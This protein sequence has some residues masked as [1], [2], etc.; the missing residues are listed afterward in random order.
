MRKPYAI[1][2]IHS[3]GH[4]DT[5][6]AKNGYWRHHGTIKAAIGAA[7]RFATVTEATEA[8]NTITR[9]RKDDYEARCREE[10]IEPDDGWFA[11]ICRMRVIDLSRMA[12]STPCDRR[13]FLP[14]ELIVGEKPVNVSGLMAFT[15]GGQP[16]KCKFCHARVW[17]HEK[18][19][20]YYDIGGEQLHHCP[21]KD[22]YH[23]QRNAELADA[24]RQKR[25]R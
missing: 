17:Y 16:Y 4:I 18:Q 22:A 25:E 20:R 24:R 3:W 21:L 23:S 6:L 5:I 7:R 13:G 14:D 8:L 2:D 10:A 1:A 9:E 11:M 12:E 15:Y 19:H